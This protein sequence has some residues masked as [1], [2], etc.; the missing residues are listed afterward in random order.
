MNYRELDIKGA[1]LIKSDVFE[2]ER[3]VFRRTYCVDS[4][5]NAGI[6]TGISQGNLSIN[7]NKATLRGF[8]YQEDPYGEAKTLTCVSGSIFNVIIDLRKDS[9]TYEKVDSRV[10][11]NDSGESIYVPAGCANAWITLEDN[12]I[13]HYYMSNRY[14]PKAGKGI[15]YNDKYFSINWPIKPKI[16]SKKDLGY[17]DYKCQ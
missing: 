5:T 2:D 4:N 11:K 6:E 9:E 15:K 13:I 7:P 14:E 1:Y 17:K 12:T 8:H 10:I 16:I 3:G